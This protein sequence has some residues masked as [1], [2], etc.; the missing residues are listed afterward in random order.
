MR[1]IFLEVDGTL[2]TL[3]TYKRVKEAYQDNRRIVDIDEDKVDR[4]SQI[5]H[6]TD[7]L[8]VITSSWRGHLLDQNDFKKIELEKLFIKYGID[9]YELTPFDKDKKKVKEIKEYLNNHE[10]DEYIVIDTKDMSKDFDNHM[11][12]TNIINGLSYQEVFMAISKLTNKV[13][14]KLC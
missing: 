4:L 11:I 12:T 7:A 8:V 3:E 9:Y 10:V 6:D 1:V 14:R 5:V 2:N 13:K